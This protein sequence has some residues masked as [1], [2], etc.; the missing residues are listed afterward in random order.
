MIKLLYFSLNINK[1]YKFILINFFGDI[2]LGGGMAP[3]SPPLAPPLY[4]RVLVFSY[5]NK[6]IFNA[7]KSSTKIMKIFSNFSQN[8]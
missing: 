2:L 3:A 1:V 7:N 8:V 4:A 5:E 6:N